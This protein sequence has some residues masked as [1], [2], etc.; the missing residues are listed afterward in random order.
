M[1][2]GSFILLHAWCPGAGAWLLQPW[3]FGDGDI[4]GEEACVLVVSQNKQV[5]STTSF[6]LFFRVISNKAGFF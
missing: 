1:Q 4:A 6:F 5:Y 3:L 2:V